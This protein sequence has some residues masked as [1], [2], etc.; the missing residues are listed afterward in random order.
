MAYGDWHRPHCTPLPDARC[1]AVAGNGVMGYGQPSSI[2]GGTG[3]CCPPPCAAA[4]VWSVARAPVA[5]HQRALA[6]GDRKM[7]WYTARLIP[8]KTSSLPGEVHW[9]QDTVLSWLWYSVLAV[10]PERRC[11]S[12]GTC[13]PVGVLGMT[14]AHRLRLVLVKSASCCCWASGT[15]PTSTIA[16]GW[17]SAGDDSTVSVCRRT[18]AST[19]TT[20]HPS[21]VVEEISSCC[22]RRRQ[23]P[24]P[25]PLLHPHGCH[26][27]GN[28]AAVLA[29]RPPVRTAGGARGWARHRRLRDVPVPPGCVQCSQHQCGIDGSCG[30]HR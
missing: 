10:A 15:N 7:A 19:R 18:L 17:P 16:A 3:S 20:S 30:V 27:G 14:N 2:T 13:V 12:S 28:A 1:T 8:G 4:K 9:D 26:T 22:C 6:Q 21:A 24:G 29:Q 25:W 23:S 5:I 11:G